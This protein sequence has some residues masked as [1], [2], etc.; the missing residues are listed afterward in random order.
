MALLQA[1]KQTENMG[2]SMDQLQA[3][4]VSQQ[5]EQHT[6]RDKA[7]VLAPPWQKGTVQ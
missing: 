4:Q 6:W 7:F 3:L 5:A 2:F 1:P